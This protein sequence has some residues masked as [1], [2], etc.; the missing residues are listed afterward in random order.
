M[1]SSIIVP[2]NE[3]L[4]YLLLGGVAGLL[5]AAS[6]WLILRRYFGRLGLWIA[7]NLLGGALCAVIS[8]PLT[9]SRSLLG[10]AVLGLLTGYALIIMGRTS[11]AETHYNPIDDY[12]A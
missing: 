2:L 1:T 6:Q 4:R 12:R 7:A 11:R 5:M 9:V 8:L 3:S 10:A